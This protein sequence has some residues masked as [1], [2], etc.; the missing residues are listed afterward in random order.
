MRYIGRDPEQAVVVQRELDRLQK[1]RKNELKL[2]RLVM[3]AKRRLRESKKVLAPLLAEEGFAFHGYAIRRCRYR[4]NSSEECASCG[5]R[6]LSSQLQEAKEKTG[7][8]RS[9]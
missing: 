9:A 7:H 4:R 3:T 5:A 1:Q 2:A 6:D 8:G